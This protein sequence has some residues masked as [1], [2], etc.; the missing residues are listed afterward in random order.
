MG[1]S[2]SQ[3]IWVGLT[4]QL[5]NRRDQELRFTV[6]D[7]PDYYQIKV[8]VFNDDK[9]TEL[10]GEAWIDLRDIV[11]PGGGQSDQWHQ[12]GCRGKYAGEVRIEI[13]YYD[14][15]PKPEKPV[16]KAKPPVS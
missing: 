10:I 16:V 7:S 13:T 3:V 11:V 4:G 14:A 6:H 1:P 8:S 12:L 5:G 2:I 15:R 9:K